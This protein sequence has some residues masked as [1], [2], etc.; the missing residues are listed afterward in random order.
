MKNVLATIRL[1]AKE[2]GGKSK[3]IG[4]GG[5]YSCPVF[6]PD[7]S[8]LSEHGW[9]CRL[10]LKEA[11]LT[12]Q[13]GEAADTVA[14]AFLSPSDVLPSLVVGTRFVLWEW[15]AIGEGFVTHLHCLP[16]RGSHRAVLAFQ[17]ALR[18]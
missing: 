16:G 15:G 7:V 3:P 5:D 2:D 18:R 1:K 14:V 8:S 13:P 10:L 12:L 11:G 9:E 17:R 6:F 4:G